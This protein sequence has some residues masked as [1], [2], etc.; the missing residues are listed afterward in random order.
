MRTIIKNTQYLN[1]DFEI[2]SNV[3]IHIEDDIF[4]DI[5][6]CQKIELEDLNALTIDGKDLLITPAFYNA[7]AHSPMWQFRSVGEGLDLES[8]LN[9][10]IWPR[11][12]LL[13]SEDVYQSTCN[14]LK[15]SLLSG[16]VSTSDMYFF[17]E[18]MVQSYKDEGVKGNISRS[19]IEFD[20]PDYNL[21]RDQ[22]FNEALSLYKKF[23]NSNNEMIKI[24]FSIHASYTTSPA[25]IKQLSD[26]L[27]NTDSIAH[28]HLS[29]TK[30]ENHQC[31]TKHQLSPTQ[32]FYQSGLFNSKVLAAHCVY[33][34]DTDL[35]II[36]DHNA[37]VAHCPVSNLKLKSGIANLSKIVKSNINIAIGTDSVASNN[38]L[39]FPFDLKTAALLSNANLSESNDFKQIMPKDLF[40]MA[41]RGGAIAQNRYNCG[42][43]DKGFKA[44]YLAIDLNAINLQ[45][46]NDI[47]TNLVYSLDSQN[48]IIVSVDGKKKVD[49]R[50]SNSV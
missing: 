19:L 4:V 1:K 22:R 2:I 32:F 26:Y 8:W 38:A 6:N 9:N 20:A 10:E 14:A 36:K 28:I 17:C 21:Y 23:H 44:D 15:E 43:I 29:E 31:Q 34:S 13:K 41:S 30:A 16:I 45:P 25:Q 42:F 33:L 18:A 7:H 11:E 35:K 49:R 3:D 24:D 5:V 39:N 27:K 37:S 46:H 50:K 40:Y 12:E 48:I 47:L